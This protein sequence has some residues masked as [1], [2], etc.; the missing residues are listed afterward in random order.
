MIAPV[1]ARSAKNPRLLRVFALLALL[2]GA[3]ACR[4]NATEEE[5]AATSGT[6]LQGPPIGPPPDR[7]TPRVGMA[8]I[9]GGALV[10]GTP[11]D[12]LPRIADE[13]MAGEQVILDEFYID[14]FLY[15]NEEGAIPVTGVTQE[16][17]RALCAEQ[18]KRLCTEL[19]WER[20][21][22]G[23]DNRTYEYG[24]QYRPSV[25]DTGKPAQLRPS[26]LNVAC[27]S[28]FGVHDM[29]GSA[30]EWTDSPWGRGTDDGRVTIRGGND[31]AGELVARCANG[32]PERPDTRSGVI[33]FRCCLG[34]RNAAEVN[35]HLA[36]GRG[37]LPRA[38]FDDDLER[39][40]IDAL[41]DEVRSELERVGTI[42]AH[43][44]W[45]WRPIGNEELHVLALCA[46]GAVPGRDQLCGLSVSRVTLGRV[47]VLAWANSG[48]WIPTL[49]P[50]YGGVRDLWMVGGDRIGSFKRLL[51]YRWGRVHTGE[52][53][54]GVPK[55]SETRP[56]AQ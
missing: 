46:R 56:K 45:L 28:D 38:K 30:W 51:A 12:K 15:P 35:L 4:G 10:A 41:P 8:W 25:C 31:R 23:P 44:A 13:E 17:A 18:G 21:C 36:F 34:P 37:L 43:R 54:R 27:R 6:E 32:R 3:A 29:H 16:E 11:A 42:R 7:P 19:E 50:M 22:K 55:P 14:R 9:P 47:D 40:L 52:M 48:L 39:A 26:G 33:G 49:H 24:E 5:P 53:S 2:G 20:A 1:T